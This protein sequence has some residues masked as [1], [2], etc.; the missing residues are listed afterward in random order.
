MRA[1]RRLPLALTTMALSGLLAAPLAALPFGKEWARGAQLP[2]PVGIG[3]DLF[4][5]DQPYTI[6]GLRFIAPGLPFQ[7]ITGAEVENTVKHV[8]VKFDVWLFPFL[9]VFA[10][11]GELDATTTVD[12]RNVP[13]PLPIQTIQ[14]DY[15]GLVYG[16]GVTLAAGGDRWFG[17]LTVNAQET[18]LSGD[19]DSSVESLVVTPKIGL[20]GGLGAVWV[21]AMYLTAD[22]SHRGVLRVPVLG[23]VDF[24][25]SLG[26]D[27]QWHGLIGASKTFKDHWQLTLEGGFGD[28]TTALASLSYRF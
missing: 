12:L 7:T 15:S 27:S 2:R 13:Q 17:S 11:I 8:D 28:K 1:L 3:I 10:I 14:V 24:D 22:E 26:E 21:G 5:M 4:G 23:T 25:V 20:Q 6:E 9:N 16:L 19:F 18:D